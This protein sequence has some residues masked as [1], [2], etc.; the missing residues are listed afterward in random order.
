MD[1]VTTYDGNSAVNP[2]LHS[3]SS[4][5]PGALERITTEYSSANPE[6]AAAE[7]DI[8]KGSENL[9]ESSKAAGK[10]QDIYS[11]IEEN[12]QESLNTVISN[13]LKHK[14]KFST[15]D[16][17]DISYIEIS[18]KATNELLRTIPS[19]AMR[20]VLENINDHIDEILNENID[21]TKGV[22]LDMSS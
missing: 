1:S 10:T 5:K 9:K 19:E 17:S 13:L 3:S 18:D 7:T 2:N 6:A 21:E 16:D 8:V 20:N 4:F 14:V 22:L 11:E 12:M 15:D